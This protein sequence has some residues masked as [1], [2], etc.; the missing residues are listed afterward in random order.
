MLVMAIPA[1]LMMGRSR[2]S[3]AVNVNNYNT[4]NSST[5]NSNNVEI[6]VEAPGEPNCPAPSPAPYN[7]AA[8]EQVEE[9]VH[10][11]VEE[12]EEEKIWKILEKA[13]H[14]RTPQERLAVDKWTVQQDPFQM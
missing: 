12:G 5:G 7:I 2:D 1:K 9:A 6:E 14:L 3:G 8:I 11:A 10:P 13:V 4:A